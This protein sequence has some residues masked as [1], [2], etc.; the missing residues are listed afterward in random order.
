MV[1]GSLIEILKTIVQLAPLADLSPFLGGGE[2]VALDVG[3]DAQLYAAIALEAL[4]DRFEDANG[5]SFAKATPA[6]PQT[7]RVLAF[8]EGE[9]TLDL[10]IAGE[11]FNIHHVQPLPGGELLLAGARSDFQGR[12]TGAPDRNGRVY[13]AE[14]RL[15]RELLLGDGIQSVQATSS[16]VIWTSYFDEGVLGNHGWRHPVGAAGLVA[17][18]AHGRRLEGFEPAGGLEPILNCYALNVASEQSTWIYYHPGFPL[19]HLRERRVEEQWA[20]PVHRSG[21]F[22][23]WGRS[24]LFAGGS[25]AVEEYH[26][27]DL[28]QE[29]RIE[30]VARLTLR[31][32]TGAPLSAEVVMGRGAA[33][34]L[35]RGEQVYRCDVQVAANAMRASAPR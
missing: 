2:L 9:P 24:A 10:V 21:A 20:V 19:V 26:L 23:V 32:E 17:W 6:K 5:S 25:K 30:E 14:G 4:D 11:R 27:F 28:G 3:P 22:A 8:Y 33:L 31:D 7:Y 34:Y 18:D 12:G 16:G 15:L 13:S 35:L 29:E 1:G